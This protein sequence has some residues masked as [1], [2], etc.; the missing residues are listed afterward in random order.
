MISETLLNNCIMEARKAVGDSGQVQ[1]VIKTL[2]GRGYRFIA[3]TTEWSAERPAS[4]HTRALSS[5]RAT[6]PPSHGHVAPGMPT[7]DEPI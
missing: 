7:Q 1:H 5:P 6:A 4:C 2:H 3:P